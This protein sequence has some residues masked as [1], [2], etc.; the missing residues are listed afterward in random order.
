MDQPKALEKALEAGFR[1]RFGSVLHYQW[2]FSDGTAD[3]EQGLKGTAALVESLQSEAGVQGSLG[4][5][6]LIHI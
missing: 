4:Y 1:R 3:M 5:L 2:I 6:S